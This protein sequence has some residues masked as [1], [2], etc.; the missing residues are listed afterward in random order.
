[1]SFWNLVGGLIGAAIIASIA[2]AILSY[3]SIVDWF[4][5]RIGNSSTNKNRLAVT[6]FQKIEAGDFQVVQGVFN[7]ETSEFESQRV[8]EANQVDRD[9]LAAHNDGIAVWEV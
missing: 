4:R 8:V 5:E 3:D 1:M 7:S 6:V 2:V 9:F